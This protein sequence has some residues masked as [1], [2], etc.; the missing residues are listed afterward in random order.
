[1]FIFSASFLFLVKNKNKRNQLNLVELLT[2]NVHTL[3]IN[4]DGDP[5]DVLCSYF[6]ALEYIIKPNLSLFNN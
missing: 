6:M 5:D 3:A 2:I 4:R 1:M